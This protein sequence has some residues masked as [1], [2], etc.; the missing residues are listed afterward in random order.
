VD[1][2]ETLEE[3]AIEGKASFLNAGGKEYHYIACLNENDTWVRAFTDIALDNL[4][5][6][7][8]ENWDKKAARTTAEATL[9]RAKA[10][11]AE[12]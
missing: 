7:V 6:W 8:S 11:G 4:G 5:G 1:C 3:I 12:H 2:L 10:L 9:A